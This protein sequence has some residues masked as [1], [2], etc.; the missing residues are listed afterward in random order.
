[1]LEPASRTIEAPFPRE[2]TM[3]LIRRL[4]S[5]ARLA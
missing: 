2:A 4:P 3:S 1:M 5:Y